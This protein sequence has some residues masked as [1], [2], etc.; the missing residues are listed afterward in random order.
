MVKA[1]NGIQQD[2]ELQIPLYFDHDYHMSCN[3]NRGMNYK[4]RRLIIS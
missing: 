2:E 1:G 3:S 4:L